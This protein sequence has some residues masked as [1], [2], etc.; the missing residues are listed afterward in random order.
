MSTDLVTVGPK[1]S[2]TRVKEIFDQNKFH[3]IPV[4]E[5]NSLRGI[6]S[7][8][9]LLF[10]MRGKIEETD[11]YGKALEQ[12]RMDRITAGEIMTTNLA[13]LEADDPIRTAISVFRKNKFHALPVIENDKLVG[14]VTT[15]DLIAL[16][17]EEPI[18]MD[19]YVA[20]K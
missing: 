1:D 17:D 11:K 18:N 7:K 5:F 13:K 8:D 2:L 4:V 19:E 3:H 20:K 12:V 6:I 14:I 15:F 9:D 10:Y 16:L